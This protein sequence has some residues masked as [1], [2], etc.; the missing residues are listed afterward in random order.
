MPWRSEASLNTNPQKPQKVKAA[1]CACHTSIPMVR[2]QRVI[3]GKP[4]GQL[5]TWQ[6]TASN[7]ARR[8]EIASDLHVNCNHGMRVSR[9]VYSDFKRGLTRWLRGKFA[10]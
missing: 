5:V 3:P 1:L 4:A 2:A 6:E 7:K 10:E 8:Q 9:R